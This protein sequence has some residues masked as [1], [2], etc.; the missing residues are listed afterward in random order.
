MIKCEYCGSAEFTRLTTETFE[1]MWIVELQ[2]WDR[3]IPVDC[4]DVDICC[5]QCGRLADNADFR[6]G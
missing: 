6:N 4:L 1:Q 3:K 2:E 5:S